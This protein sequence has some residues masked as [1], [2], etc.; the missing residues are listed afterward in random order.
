LHIPPEQHPPDGGGD[1]GAADFDSLVRAM[2]LKTWVSLADPQELHF[3]EAAIFSLSAME[4]RNSTTSPH[5]L[6]RYSYS[7][8]IL[9]FFVV[10][11]WFLRQAGWIAHQRLPDTYIDFYIS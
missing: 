6:H 11:K 9:D 3:R 2:P 7:G 1:E 5:S 4:E 10:V 8:M